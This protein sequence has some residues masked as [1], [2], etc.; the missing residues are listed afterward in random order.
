MIK[1]FEW[2]DSFKIK[3]CKERKS[4]ALITVEDLA[5]ALLERRVV[6]YKCA[7]Q[8]DLLDLYTGL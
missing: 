7:A 8:C 4:I 2:T 6:V 3:F 5:T 1:K